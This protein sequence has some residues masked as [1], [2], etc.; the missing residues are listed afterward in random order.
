[1]RAFVDYLV[2]NDLSDVILLG[3]SYGGMVVTGVADRVPE[4][5][6]R[7]IYWTGYVP[8]H[9]ESCADMSPPENLPIFEALAAER[10]D[11]AVMIPFLIWRELF[12]ND[13][14]LETAKQSY[15]RLNPHPMKTLTDKICL[16]KN[17]A[18]MALPKLERN[19]STVRATDLCLLAG[20]LN[21]GRV[22]CSEESGSR[23]TPLICA[24][25]M[26]MAATTR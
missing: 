26:P 17:P 18:E 11:G 9:G 19:C 4:R 5:L 1:M 24:A 3:H 10:S 22:A 20:F 12:L 8:N 23:S 2:E 16:R 13:A 7:L 6:R 25:S 15:Q 14:D 21:T